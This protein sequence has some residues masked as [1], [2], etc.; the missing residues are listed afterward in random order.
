MFYRNY[1]F[2]KWKISIF[3]DPS[4]DSKLDQSSIEHIGVVSIEVCTE[5]IT[6]LLRDVARADVRM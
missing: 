1:S 4:I 3:I 5:L 2:W 6:R